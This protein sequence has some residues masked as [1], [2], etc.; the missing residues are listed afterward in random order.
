MNRRTGIYAALLLTGAFLLP[1]CSNPK[2]AHYASIWGDW[3]ADVPW[4]WRVVTEGDAGRFTN[5][6]FIGPFDPNFLMGAPSL[7]VRWHGYNQAHR[8][9]DGQLEIYESVDDYVKQVLRDVYQPHAKMIDDVKD[10]PA[11]TLLDGRSGKHF[12]VTS[13]VRVPGDLKW[14]TVLDA[15]SG[16]PYNVRE[17]AYVLVPMKR[18]FYVLI[19]P[20]TKDDNG[21]E[22]YPVYEALFNQLVHS[23]QA[24]KDGPDGP[25]APSAPYKLHP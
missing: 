19:Y 24:L 3:R 13:P 23:F 16:K 10:L 6:D 21:K 2:Y 5:T 7:S 25:P 22:G 9:P 8:L 12:V 15:D 14:G 1:G 11:D 20:A 4:G 17:H 18:G